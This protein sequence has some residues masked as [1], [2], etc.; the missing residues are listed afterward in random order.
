M[1]D[2]LSPL[3]LDQ[4][5]ENVSN[6]RSVSSV[7]DSGN[8]TP[9]CS[10]N[11]DSEN[12]ST[13]AIDSSANTMAAPM[14]NSTPDSRQTQHDSDRKVSRITT[15]KAMFRAMVLHAMLRRKSRVLMAIIAS[16]VG[17]ATL[18]C[19]ASI[20]ITVPRQIRQELRT[21]GANFVLTS[22]SHDG[23]SEEEIHHVDAMMSPYGAEHHAGYRYDMVR[24]H[25]LQHM[26]AGINVNEVRTM[27]GYWDVQGSWPKTGEVLV[28]RN[29]ATAWGVSV[30]SVV[31]IGYQ[32]AGSGQGFG[33]D[34]SGAHHHHHHHNHFFGDFGNIG[35]LDMLRKNTTVQPKHMHMHH[36]E[37]PPNELEQQCTDLMIRQGHCGVNFR[38]SG[39]VQTGGEQ[40]AMLYVTEADRVKLVGKDRGYDVVEYS[41]AADAQQLKTLAKNVNAL[42]AGMEAR[43]VSRVASAD[44]HIVIML[45]LLFWIIA[46]VV[47]ALTFLGVG[48]TISSIVVQRRREIGLRKA[49]GASWQSIALE[50]YV[51]SAIYGA[52]GG[53]LGTFAGLEAANWLSQTVFKR[54]LEV[55]WWLIVATIVSSI[56]LAVAACAV[57]VHTASRIDPARVLREE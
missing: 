38:V 8:E 18:I 30:G 54:H 19:L 41:S 35:N 53:V 15:N 2:K 10:S 23:I 40:D 56:V 4:G 48:T 6:D 50:F 55:L 29:L 25:G 9:N 5:S 17:A 22:T 31:V 14:H 46:I 57:P 34:H 12:L 32:T 51:E 21:F 13:S 24:V 42:Q 52:I 26:L 27:N 1:T 28:G 49:L 36:D 45:Q 44:A 7:K 47:L 33:P 39:I 16:L 20:S 43:P 37:Q 3:A 11:G